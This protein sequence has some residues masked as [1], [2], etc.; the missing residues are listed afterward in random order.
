MKAIKQ[1]TCHKKDMCTGYLFDPTGKKCC[2]TGAF[3]RACGVEKAAMIDKETD[4]N[5]F[6][7]YNLLHEELSNLYHVDLDKIEEVINQ[8]M[9]INDHRKSS[10][11]RRFAKIIKVFKEIGVKVIYKE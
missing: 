2:V 7:K 11:K 9:E 3:Y 10:W 5:L 6:G 8:A 1:F 4:E